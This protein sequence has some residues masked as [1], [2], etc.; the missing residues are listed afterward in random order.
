MLDRIAN[1][2]LTLFFKLF[3]PKPKP[4]KPATPSLVAK[5]FRQLFVDHGVEETRIPR[6][7]AKITLDDLKSD[8]SLLKKLTPNLINEA[9][10]LFKVRAEW[11]HI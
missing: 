6:I 5:R 9:A 3:E 4:I 2:L 1:K 8:E 11:I 10:E 7:F